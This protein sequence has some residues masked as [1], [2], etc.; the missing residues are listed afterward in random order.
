MDKKVFEA[1]KTEHEKLKSEYEKLKGEKTKQPEK[2][3]DLNDKTKKDDQDL[4]EKVKKE[5]ELMAGKTSDV[6]NLES[7]VQFNYKINDFIKDHENLLPSDIESIVKIAEKESF[8]TQLDKANAVKDGMIKSFF[9]IDANTQLL[10]S[11][12]KSQLDDY[13]KLTK[14]S[15]LEKVSQV[16]DNVFEPA[17]ELIKKV[18]KAEEVGRARYGISSKPEDDYKNKLLKL[19][20]RVHLNEKGE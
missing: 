12:Q 4:L 17:L 18:K 6:K 20:K 10:T 15:R 11:S 8:D 3:D 19:A 7:A 2:K 5:K 1:L 16:Y 13:L 9:S 14:N